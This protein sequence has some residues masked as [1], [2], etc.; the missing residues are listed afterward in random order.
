MKMRHARSLSLSQFV[1]L[2]IFRVKSPWACNQHA[3]QVNLTV[4]HCFDFSLCSGRLWGHAY[5]LIWMIDPLLLC[6]RNTSMLL[7]SPSRREP[8]SFVW[9]SRIL[10][11]QR[12]WMHPPTVTDALVW[13]A[14]TTACTIYP[15]HP[16]N[17]IL[18]STPS[19]SSWMKPQNPARR[20]NTRRNRSRGDDFETADVPWNS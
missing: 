3:V 18:M 6:T 12:S 14:T 2:A 10:K 9:L 1:P 5:R 19:S 7:C 15:S 8:W 11:T 17:M 13:S 16:W 4:W 20:T